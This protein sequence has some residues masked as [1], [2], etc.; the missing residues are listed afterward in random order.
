MA[1]KLTEKLH[2]VV[3]PELKQK[4]VEAAL[5]EQRSEGAIIRLALR[6]YFN[7]NGNDAG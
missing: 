4:V 6:S 2:T 3:D 1:R 7:M 5:K